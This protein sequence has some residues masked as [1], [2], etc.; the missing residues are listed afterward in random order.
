MECFRDFGSRWIQRVQLAGTCWVHAAVVTQLYQVVHQGEE[1][2][3]ID[4]AKY[5]RSTFTDEKLSSYIVTDG[6]GNSS[7][8]FENMLE[9]KFILT[10][11]HSTI[12]DELNEHEGTDDG[13]Q[14]LKD[15]REHGPALAHCFKANRAFKNATATTDAE[16]KITSIPF[17]TKRRS[18]TIRWKNTL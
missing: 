7:E 4:I 18:E 14:L 6:G 10:Y 12:L 11:D 3:V 15:I 16:G 9:K 17:L 2:E 5:A 1:I 8:E 13:L